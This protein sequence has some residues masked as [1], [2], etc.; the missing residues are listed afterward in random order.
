[1]EIYAYLLLVW[2]NDAAC[3]KSAVSFIHARF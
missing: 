2:Q 1:M 3:E